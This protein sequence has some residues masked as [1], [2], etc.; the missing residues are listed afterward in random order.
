MRIYSSALG[1]TL[2]SRISELVP[3]KEP[4]G[5]LRVTI[6]SIEPLPMQ[7]V[8]RVE[9]CDLRALLKMAKR[10]ATMARILRLALGA[11]KG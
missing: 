11:V 1:M 9:S 8:C 6:D 7:F 3:E 10:P 2:T 5:L 4:G